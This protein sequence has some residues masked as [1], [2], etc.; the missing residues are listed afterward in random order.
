ML[1]AGLALAAS[2][3]VPAALPAP[4]FAGKVVSPDW[5]MVSSSR[6]TASRSG[7]PMLHRM[8][9]THT[10][11]P[12]PAI[13]QVDLPIEKGVVLLDIGF[14][15]S[16]PNHG[17]VRSNSWAGL[18]RAQYALASCAGVCAHCMDVASGA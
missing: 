7:A 10:A 3:I 5:E 1:G 17:E 16:D 13:A 8:Q 2:S 12:C 6:A 4:A 9:A 15:G 14:T 18:Q 11:R